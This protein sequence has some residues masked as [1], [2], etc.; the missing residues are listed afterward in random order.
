VDQI[1]EVEQ[2]IL[3]LSRGGRGILYDWLRDLVEEEDRIGRLPYL[4]QGVGEPPA[5]AYSTRI[6]PYSMSVQEYLEFEE[7]TSIKHEYVAGLVF[8]MSG[9][10]EAHET[11][12]DNLRTALRVHLHGSP[13]RT[14]GSALQVNLKMDG[15]EFYYHP[16]VMV[17]CGQPDLQKNFRTDPRL[18]VEVLS[19]STQNIDRRE[20]YEN[21]RKIATLEEYIVVAQRIPEVTIFRRAENWLGQ[22]LKSLEETADFRSIQLSLPLTRIYEGVL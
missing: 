20:K 2:A 6:E 19:P 7:K 1:K 9:P 5:P 17:A 4:S 22:T 12:A 10:T 14:F 11:I 3:K 15:D 16:D 21:Y 18:L 13:C 8:A